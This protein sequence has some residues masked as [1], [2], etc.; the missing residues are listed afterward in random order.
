[1]IFIVT[2]IFIGY[3]ECRASFIIGHLKLLHYYYHRL[4]HSPTSSLAPSLPSA[5]LSSL[6]TLSSSLGPSSHLLLKPRHFHLH[7]HLHL[8]HH[9][10]SFLSN[11]HRNLHLY[12]TI[13][14]CI[15]SFFS[16]TNLTYLAVITSDIMFSLLIKFQFASSFH[17]NSPSPIFQLPLN[18]HSITIHDHSILPMILNIFK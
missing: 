14:L 11:L 16:T 4:C 9:P 8:H 7:R 15:T 6:P 18:H 1:M 17:N 12:P 5:A 3:Y 13:S 2:M 10:I